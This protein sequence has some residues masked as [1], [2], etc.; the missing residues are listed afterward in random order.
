MHNYSWAVIGLMAVLLPWTTM[1]QGGAPTVNLAMNQTSLQV[2]SVGILV[3][4]SLWA[5]PAVSWLGVFGAYMGV[6]ALF[7]RTPFAFETAQ[8]IVFGIVAIAVLRRTPDRWRRV[9]RTGLVITGSFQIIYAVIQEAGYSPFWTGTAYIGKGWTSGTIGNPNHLGAYLAVTSALVPVWALPLW[10]LG[11]ALSRSALASLGTT[12]ALG[13]RFR[14]HWKIALPACVLLVGL[15]FAV[16]GGDV[17]GW[18]ERFL[19]ARVALQGAALRPL[20]GHG[21]GSWATIGPA[22]QDATS[23]RDR[24]ASAARWQ[25]VHNEPAQ[26]WFEGGA[27]ALIP[28]AVWIVLN[29]AAFLTDH[30]GPAAAA[31]GLISLASFP[32]HIPSLMALL[33]TVTG[34]ALA[35][36]KETDHGKR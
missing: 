33:L 9:L 14:T 27:L 29:R 5:I 12:L 18:S 11:L 16:R 20:V 22:L 2:W 23:I 1:I 17:N 19:I 31:S 10:A 8:A 3:A 28:V 4:V 6:R 30:F 34:L 26:L 32:F 36:L 15:V 35:P 24:F 13:I 25:E 7:T 21:P